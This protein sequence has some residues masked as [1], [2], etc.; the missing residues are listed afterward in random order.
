MKAPTVNVTTRALMARI[1]R[2]LAHEGQKLCTSRSHAERQN[3][4]N[5]HLID[6]NRNT[7]IAYPINDLEKWARSEMPDI[8]KP[9]ERLAD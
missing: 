7:V 5:Y 3:L 9:Y 2:Q 6:A 8:L 1:N 4:G